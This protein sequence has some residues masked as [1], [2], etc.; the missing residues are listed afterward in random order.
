MKLTGLL[1]GVKI[2]SVNCDLN[3]EISE[4][5]AHSADVKNGALFF[6][7]RGGENDGNNY[8][9][10]AVASGAAVVVSE[11]P[12]KEGV[13]HIV[14]ANVRE[15]MGVVAANFY[16]NVEKDLKIIT[17][18][19]TNGKTTTATVLANLLR[20]A[21]KKVALIGT[22]GADLEGEKRETALT[23]PD[24]LELHALFAAA[25]EKGINY[26][27]ME[28]SAH[29]IY[30]RKLSGI[31]ADIAIF[32]NFSQDHLD[33]FPTMEEYEAVKF[34]YFTPEN[35]RYAVVNADDPL[36]VKIAR[37]DLPFSTTFGLY[38]PADSFA[39]DITYKDGKTACLINCRDDIFD[40]ETKLVGD[41]NVYNILGAVTAARL[42]GV[43]VDVIYN[44][45][46]EM[47][48]VEGRFNLIDGKKRVVIDF[49][50]TPDGLSNLL[51]AARKET[52]G[53]LIVVFGC[54]G[55]RD[56]K[57]R[58]IMGE[59]A[60]ELADFIILTE[61]NSRNER[62]EDIISQIEVGVLKKTKNYIKINDRENAVT[63]AV[64]SAN[65]E[66][67]VVIAG[68]GGENY[69]ETNGIKRP[70]SDKKVVADVFGRYGL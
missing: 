62:T 22:L 35:V 45:L 61:D 68:K 42:L 11:Y 14:V 60:A 69:I 2:T 46:S 16:K 37:K 44:A 34:G 15:S 18:V 51:K 59:I 3:T 25:V 58:P 67:L 40:I 65:K 52:R 36:G 30:F 47:N 41:F 55:N 28:A 57:K 39:M 29:A 7:V 8:V 17:V 13:P 50:H 53:R 33:F 63:Y 24:P 9:H 5:T 27:V 38:N 26:V 49:A 10:D 43:P 12:Q 54:G 21:G 64:L 4:L 70:Y 31:V 23:T 66:D 48:P 32:T 20:A 56:T 19:G 6:A 1:T